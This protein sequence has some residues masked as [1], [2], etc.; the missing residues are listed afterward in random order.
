[1]FRR[2]GEYWSIAF[3]GQAFRLK[4][5]KGLHY[6]AHLLRHPGRELHALDLAAAGMP[7]RATCS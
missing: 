7:V 4:D 3:D 5:T 1:V 6:P 2:E